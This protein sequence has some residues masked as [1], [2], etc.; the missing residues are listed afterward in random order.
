MGTQ[1]FLGMPPPNVVEWIKA[2]RDRKSPL[3]F[4]AN[5]AG[6]SVA[7]LCWD[8]YN[9]QPTTLKCHL[10]YSTDKMTTWET[11]DGSIVE[12]DDCMDNRVY[13][14]ADPEN[15][16]TYG[17]YKEDWDQGEAW[18]HYFKTVKS[19]KAGGNIQFLLEST[20]TRTDVPEQ[21]FCMLFGKDEYDGETYENI[22]CCSSLTT[23]P[24]LP[25]TTLA[26]NCYY[27]MF[28]GCSSLTTAPALP[29]M[30]LAGNCY[31][32][33]FQEC[34]SLITAPALPATTLA[35]SCYSDMFYGCTSLTTAPALPAMTLADYCYRGMFQ[36]CTSLT[37]APT[38]PAMTLADNC[39]ANM[40]TYCMSLTTAPV[41]LAMTLTKGCYYSM[42]QS[43]SNLASID[44]GFTAWN[45][46]N[47][48]TDWVTG[49]AAS[50]TFTC[51]STLPKTTG[52]SNIP[53]GW[54]II[55]K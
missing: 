52:N 12:L 4:E 53:D 14:R 50:G 43:C 29:A 9:Y 7:M 11:Y 32:S 20:G 13:F 38:L 44:V 42:F 49:V 23:A 26:S 40:F 1:V 18:T 10:Q 41:L 17:F 15:P 21:G 36:E 25:A 39:Y 22:F 28:K 8:D 34:T 55:E 54:T 37:T 30:T 45:P 27:S 2:E 31:Q 33:M 24:V 19:V 47:A 6:A 5:E 3:F 46:T 51:P 35:N 16:N 48:T